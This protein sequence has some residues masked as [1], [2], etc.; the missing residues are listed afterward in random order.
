MFV[1]IVGYLFEK[2]Q[3]IYSCMQYTFD[4]E[5][6]TH[7]K[8]HRATACKSVRIDLAFAARK[9]Q[10]AC[11]HLQPHHAEEEIERTFADCTK[12]KQKC[13]QTRIVILSTPSPF[14]ASVCP[15]TAAEK[16][17]ITMFNSKQSCGFRRKLL[18]EFLTRIQFIIKTWPR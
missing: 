18:Y 5:S 1:E 9:A 16:S 8:F 11:C 17:Q 6:T 2:I 4:L 3:Y 7:L 12:L 10:L 13:F 14:V 15:S